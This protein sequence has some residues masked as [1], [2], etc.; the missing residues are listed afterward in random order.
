MRVVRASVLL[1]LVSLAA[2]AAV[3]VV[4]TDEQMVRS[5]EAIVVGIARDSW[6]R[7]LPGRPI[8]TVTR[9]EVVEAIRGGF[10]SID[11]VSPGGVAGELGLLVPGA[12]TFER[13]ERV[14]LFL[15]RNA[16]GEWAP[17]DMT[18]GKF[19]FSESRLLRAP[20]CGFDAGGAAY[21][22]R[23]RSAGRFLH[24]VRETAR[25]RNAP[26][27]YFLEP[28][29]RSATEKTAQLD[30]APASTYAMDFRGTPIR[31][32][33]FPAAVV[34]HSNGTQPNA[35]AGGLTAIQRGLAA[36][37]DDA[38]SNIVYQHGGTTTSTSGLRAADGVNSIVFND[39]AG[40]VTAPG[41]LAIGG[42]YFHTSTT[43]RFAGE[44]FIDVLEADLVIRRD[45]AL[46][47]VGGPG[48][49]RVVTHE[50]GHTLA[51]RHSDEPPA[52]G[53]SSSAAIMTSVVDFHN[54]RVGSALQTWDREAV[55]AV[56]GSGASTPPA[57]APPAITEHPSSVALGGGDVT[58]SVGATG[59]GPL[60]YQW[61]AGSRGDTRA[62]VANATGPA[63]TVRPA[64][65]TSYWVRVSGACAPPADS[66]AGTVTVNG[67]PAVQVVSVTSSTS[68][69]QGGSVT[70]ALSVSAAGRP[71]AVRWFEG[72]R[73]D[74]SVPLG[75]SEAIVVR[76]VATTHY[77][78]EVSNDCGATATT[79]AII[80][81][82]RPCTAPR[83]L[84]QPAHAESLIGGT[85]SLAATVDGTA[86]M[87]LQWFEGLGGD[88]SRPVT[89]AMSASATSPAIFAPTRFWM[90]ARNDCGE[91]ATEVVNVSVVSACAAPRIDVEPASI[92][93]APGAAA[94]L[95]VIAAGP[96][97]T[98]RWYQGP[99]LDFTRPVGVSAPHL[100]TPP[101]R[102]PT[103]FWVEVRNP[104]G[105]VS[106]AVATVT[107][108]GSRRRAAGR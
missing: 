94:I 23:Q 37:T 54:D 46:P 91:A 38:G 43:H 27:D 21:V 55:A 85:V 35:P 96:S 51:I 63:V 61:Y 56:Y 20:V 83:V 22:E 77:W 24:F 60:R 58:L 3:F 82:V 47:G 78:A 81:T 95:S 9:I 87:T 25:G 52:G 93:V 8:E 16:R 102:E 34:F 10:Q 108:A 76:P 106:S 17:L 62:P 104:C 79:E 33:S 64:Q 44:T 31:W 90:S 45:L 36:W 97:L 50:L 11:V 107:P 39:P 100:S 1:L 15:Q 57:C 5:A 28:M 12:A 65:T 80:V 6:S 7:Q 89:S 84:I 53:S 103:A 30:A 59:T 70:L 101:V 72:D 75:S 48:F 98:Y 49:E 99:R 26:A 66:N 73:G 105:S 67:C 4:S 18:L 13:D 19:R 74:K 92:S 68:I 32:S 86:P 71:L 41:V 69:V 29:L 88:T 42:V 14:L 40:E 2:E